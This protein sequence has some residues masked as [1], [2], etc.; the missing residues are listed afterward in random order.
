MMGQNCVNASKQQNKACWQAPVLNEPRYNCIL[1]W[2]AAYCHSTCTGGIV[3]IELSTRI[4]NKLHRDTQHA[5]VLVSSLHPCLPR[6]V[7]PF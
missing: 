1:P 6:T 2:F 5:C 7:I 3:I 4:N